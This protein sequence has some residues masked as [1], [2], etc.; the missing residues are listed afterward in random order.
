[1]RV[2]LDSLDLAQ[3]HGVTAQIFL[4]TAAGLAAAH[5]RWWRNLPDRLAPASAIIWNRFRW[6]GCGLVVL[7]IAQL[8]VGAIMRHQGAGLA[9]P[10]FPYSQPDGSLLPVSWNWAV[11]LNF[12]HRVGAVLIIGGVM[13]AAL[14]AWKSPQVT[15]AMRLLTGSTVALV[16]IQGL[17]G[18]SVIW[19]VRQ[20]IQTTLHVLNG[21][22]FL[23][24]LWTLTFAFCKPLLSAQK[25]FQNLGRPNLAGRSG[26]AETVCP[27]ASVSVS[28]L[29]S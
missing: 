16:I 19:S 12:A 18:A 29:T 25:S 17:L 15:P 11:G 26:T 27:A 28:T 10:T 2:L 3:V 20:P 7:T 24:V 9:I 13:G 23:S 1:M 5:S 8:V 6:I 21:A 14:L 22:I 4:C